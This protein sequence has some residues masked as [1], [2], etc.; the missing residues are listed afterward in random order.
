MNRRGRI[1]DCTW[2]RKDMVTG[3]ARHDNGSTPDPQELMQPVM[4]VRPNMPVVQSAAIRNHLA[5]QA[6]GERA[7]VWLPVQ[8]VVGDLG[9]RHDHVIIKAS[10]VRNLPFEARNVHFHL[11]GLAYHTDG[12]ATRTAAWVP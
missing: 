2:R 5:V 1:H 12:R 8:N 11:S 10:E 4:P 3:I 7:S 6:I 9:P